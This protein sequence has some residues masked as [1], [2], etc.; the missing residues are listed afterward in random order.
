MPMNPLDH[1][2]D[3][4]IISAVSSTVSEQSLS[5]ATSTLVAGIISTV[6]PDL[7][8]D[9]PNS[10]TPSFNTLE[11]V[12][13][14]TPSLI[15]AFLDIENEHV[16]LKES[17]SPDTK[18]PESKPV[19]LD[20]DSATNASGSVATEAVTEPLF[21]H[22]EHNTNTP[23]SSTSNS[24]DNTAFSTKY[25][26]LP[27]MQRLIQAISQ[28]ISEQSSDPTTPNA[29]FNPFV[30]YFISPF[31]MLCIFMALVINRTSAFASTRRSTPLPLHQRL[32][33][34]SLP[35]FLL[36]KRALTFV[37]VFSCRHERVYKFL[38]VFLRA[39]SLSDCT[40]GSMLWDLFWT[41][42]LGQF[43][44]TFSTVIQGHST[45]SEAGMS[46]F[47]YSMAFR[48]IQTE[49]NNGIYTEQ[50]IVFCFIC[51]LM[52][53]MTH[54]S[55]AFNLQDYR[56]IPSAFFSL[57]LLGYFSFS[58]Y[59]GNM[60]NFPFFFIVSYIPQ[61]LT[62]ISVLICVSI[63]GLACLFVGG[64]DNL[65]ISFK[66]VNISMRDD[67]YSCIVKL[68]IVALT[69]ASKA[70][71][72]NESA[73][74]NTPLFTWIEKKDIYDG[75]KASIDKGRYDETGSL[76]NSRRFH[77]DRNMMKRK[78]INDYFLDDPFLAPSIIQP[79]QNGNFFESSDA[80]S[81]LQSE[82]NSQF[83]SQKSAYNKE[84]PV[85][86]NI[87]NPPNRFGRPNSDTIIRRRRSIRFLLR[88]GITFSTCSSVLMLIFF[89]IYYF[90]VYRTGIA[91]AVKFFMKKLRDKRQRKKGEKAN[92]RASNM[93]LKDG[94]GK[95]TEDTSND[96]DYD[97][98]NMDQ[99]ADESDDEFDYSE[100]NKMIEKKVNNVFYKDLEETH[101]K[102]NGEN[103]EKRSVYTNLLWGRLIPDI[104]GSKDYNPDENEKYDDG[105]S[106][107]EMELEYNSD[108]TT[109][110]ESSLQP[111]KQQYA[112]TSGVEDYGNVVSLHRGSIHQHREPKDHEKSKSTL[113]DLYDLLIPSPKEFLALLDPQDSVQ[114][115]QRRLMLS[116]LHDICDD[117]KGSDVNDKKG[118]TEY[119]AVGS[120][121]DRSMAFGED[122]ETTNQSMIHRRKRKFE[123]SRV[124]PAMTR[125]Q[126][127]K[128]EWDETRA[129]SQ[130]IAERRKR[131]GKHMVSEY[132]ND[133]GRSDEIGGEGIGETLCV[134]CQCQ[135]RQIV[136][137]PC[138]CF[139]LCDDCRFTLAVKNFQGCVCCR[140]H[141]SAFSKIYV[142]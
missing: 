116:H 130:V 96:Y 56:L 137:W 61:L 64:P 87:L 142:P 105:Y 85:A 71:Y 45:Y 42:C 57:I 70:T 80:I 97:P 69:A 111:S 98:L 63:Y 50:V 78:R 68:S 8:L 55:G 28:A 114:I 88:I 24:T 140:R 20:G 112:G 41:I 94:Q 43:I 13:E 30:T 118:G 6:T 134:V 1:I 35:I 75:D 139:A 99:S 135:T 106:T 48:E 53:L 113:Q 19:L 27:I 141:V 117:N 33:I 22:S 4:N 34:R 89:N 100:Y 122:K 93:A 110:D 37:V 66:N 124:V 49:S 104:D 128:I 15:K 86:K 90:L 127:Q 119:E 25:G 132:H 136:L 26:S 44:E 81:K 23:I 16:I 29:S 12:T 72:L 58:I 92:K 32:M 91:R 95:Q 5:L 74:L 38:P 109:D 73:V 18:A 76:R 77:L 131:T 101:E 103:F 123:T 129:L 107:D 9:N 120:G 14:P 83:H 133:N 39:E 40:N 138:K 60:L 51:S 54:I 52:L 31:W 36:S 59:Q 47:E 67:F 115:E 79:D 10:R 102:G 126:Y 7:V 84:V 46:L 65:A 2:M 3:M 82:E 17:S 121:I 62:C 108:Y 21:N 11:G 125:L